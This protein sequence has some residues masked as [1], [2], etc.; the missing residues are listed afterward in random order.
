ML[1]DHLI[2]ELRY[3]EVYTTKKIRNM[4]SGTFTSRMRG[5][6]FDFDEH[7]PYRPGDDVRRID[8][9]VTARLQE[10]F[11]RLTHAERELNLLIALD[12]SRS[13]KYGTTRYSKKELTLLIAGCLV[14][15]ALADQINVGFIAFTD[16]VL[17]FDEPRRVRSKAWA[18]LDDVWKLDVPP[19]TGTSILPVADYLVGHLRKASIVCFVSDF[20]TDENLGESRDLKVLAAKHDLIGVMIEDPVEAELPPGSGTI[21][22]RDLETGRARRV[23]LSNGLRREYRNFVAERRAAMLRSFYRIPMDHVVVRGDG[24]VA[25]PLLRLFASRR[26]S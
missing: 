14:F 18:I 17:S 23:G 5:Q 13:M 15:S 10:P 21:R 16:R 4:R 20:M 19:G 1:P 26:R 24:S 11:I 8:W 2:H 9:N 6:G 3:L 12:L 25:E 22:V 7:R